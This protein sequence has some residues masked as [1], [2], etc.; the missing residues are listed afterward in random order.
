ML[1]VPRVESIAPRDWFNFCSVSQ[2]NCRLQCA[3]R[4]PTQRDMARTEGRIPEKMWTNPT[5][6]KWN[7]WL[8]LVWA[9]FIQ[10]KENGAQ[11]PIFALLRKIYYYAH[12]QR[13]ETK[14][15]E[16]VF[17][18]KIRNCFFFSSFLP[19]YIWLEA[20][21]VFR[22][23]WWYKGQSPRPGHPQL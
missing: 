16:F 20:R 2:C 23:I 12:S 18:C 11:G 10:T 1:E 4:F 13:V 9:L 19:L 5:Q 7:T 8:D 3:P 6:C 15:W 22:G 17:T 14:W 21:N